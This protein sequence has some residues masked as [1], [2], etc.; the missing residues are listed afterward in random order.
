[1]NLEDTEEDQNL[2][3]LVSDIR[4]HSNNVVNDFDSSV[5]TISPLGSKPSSA[6]N[7]NVPASRQQ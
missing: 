7:V 1:M 6:V 4:L 5:Q 3:K 2:A